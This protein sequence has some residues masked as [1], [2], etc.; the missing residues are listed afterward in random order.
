MATAWRRSAGRQALGRLMHGADAI[1]GTPA[2]NL[3]KGQFGVKALAV[4]EDDF[5]LDWFGRFYSGPH[6]DTDF[7]VTGF[8]Q[9]DGVV[10]LDP[11]LSTAV[12]AQD[13][14]EMYPEF[15]PAEMNDA[16]NAAIAMVEDEALQDK[17]DETLVAVATQWEYDVPPDFVT[18]EQIYEE[19]GTAGRYS[20]S[21][22]LLDVRHWRILPGSPPKIWFDN[23]YKTLTAG[24]KLRLVGQQAPPQ[25]TKDDDLCSVPQMYVLYQAK[26]H[27]HLA[28]VE[29]SGDDHYK[30][31]VVAQARAHEER[32][33]LLVASRGSRVAF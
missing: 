3:T 14:F 4:Y 32:K 23:T 5:F 16:I 22:A 19:S 15:S 12:E 8:T 27:L 20:P 31:M 18:V 26:A 6:K 25:L 13:L 21:G 10:E 9:T 2:T 33:R 11:D 24:R 17:R 7:V 29:E 30:K 1:T 28:R